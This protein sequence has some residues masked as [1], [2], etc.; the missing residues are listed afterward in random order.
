MCAKLAFQ[1]NAFLFPINQCPKAY[2]LTKKYVSKAYA[3][4]FQLNDIN[5]LIFLQ[6]N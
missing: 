2:H 1:Y 4:N 6:R 3:N 5:A